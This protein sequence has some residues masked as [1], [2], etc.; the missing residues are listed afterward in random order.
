MISASTLLLFMV[1]VL[2]LFLSPGPNMAFVLSY[3]TTMGRSGG[4]AAA[5]GIAVADMVFTILTAS[6]ITAMLAGWPPMFDLLRLG[7]AAYLLWLA[8]KS[9]RA[10]GMLALL[11]GERRSHRQVVRMAMLNSLLNPKALLF[12]MVFLPQFVNIAQGHVAQQVLLLGLVL[13]V[14]GL[15]FNAVLA[16][17]S[18]ALGR[19]LQS[20]PRFALWQGRALTL[21]F[22]GLA[23]R[24]L[25]LQRPGQP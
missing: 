12:F 13:A 23:A 21:V 16:Q 25:L 1:T 8:W 22:L 10:G 2:L 11:G 24:L 3:S 18:G 4:L 14:T 9:W 20:Q 15:A 7:G 17:F 5:L 19:Y 6:G